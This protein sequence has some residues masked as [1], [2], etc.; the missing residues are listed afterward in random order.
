MAR[1]T[2]IGIYFVKIPVALFLLAGLAICLTSCNK[3]PTAPVV[4]T[5]GVSEIT[6]TSA[7]SGGN[8]TDDGGAKVTSKGVCWNISE[9][10]TTAHSKTTDG[11]G[12]G[13]FTSAITQLTPGIKYYVKAF[14]TNEVGTGYGNQVSFTTDA[15]IIPTLTTA[16]VTAVAAT[17]AVSGGDITSDGGGTISARGVCWSSTSQTPTIADDRTTDG[18]G[19]GSFT[20]NIGG[21]AASTEYYVRAY[22]TNSA[23]TG[24]GDAK[25]F[26]TSEAGVG[27]I[28]FNPGLTYGTVTDIDGNTYET[29]EIGSKKGTSGYDGTGGTKATQIWMARN[30]RTTRYNDGTD[31][32]QVT[33]N[34]E[35]ISLETPAYCWHDNDAAT[36]KFA[37][38]ALYNWYAVNTGKLCPIGWHVPSDNEFK[39][40]TGPTGWTSTTGGT[41]REIGG[42]HWSPP[43]DGAT[44][45]TGF[46]ALPGGYRHESIGT[47]GQFQFKGFYWTSTAASDISTWA[48]EITSGA[49][50]ILHNNYQN[51]YGLSVRCLMD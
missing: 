34:G 37:Y 17:T 9:N 25:N 12:S 11:T 42:V 50:Y 23:G 2:K 8:V 19:T 7:S 45:E 24:Y 41:L 29:I 21:L 28:I 22:A 48:F 51:K 33:D 14:A 36:Y 6:Q 1:D 49:A 20:S 32:P 4:T 46:T 39:V 44:N 10:P 18:S 16:T 31:I 47:F 35:W 3:K 13:S 15:V 43:N 30:L 5:A 27:A 38:G 40:L 26:T